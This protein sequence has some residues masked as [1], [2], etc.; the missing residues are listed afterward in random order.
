MLSS[1]FKYSL[2]TRILNSINRFRKCKVDN[3]N[4]VPEDFFQDIYLD[5]ILAAI[6]SEFPTEKNLAILDGGCGRGKITAAVAKCGHNVTG[7]D[8]HDLS[9]IQAG[10]ESKIMG[11]S[12]NLI[13]GDLL[14]VLKSIDSNTYHV[15]LCI[16]TLYACP[17]YRDII[18][19]FKRVIKIDGLFIATFRS[20]FYFITTLL[21][22]NQYEKA[23]KV[24]KSSEGIL[25]IASIPTYYNWQSLEEIDEIYVKN[26]L[27]ILKRTPVGAFCGTAYDGMSAI[28]NLENT[29]N[30]L[31]KSL[32]K[33]LEISEINDCEGIGR[34]TLVIGKNSNT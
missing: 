33:K 9:L 12:L 1:K 11:V 17:E 13:Q 18:T 24:A 31:E 6:S 21:L 14:K 10:H 34:F 32:L 2:L 4:F 8:Y 16:E 15:G 22:Q 23:L 7:I 19:E 3:P 20:K 26:G 28:C 27:K 5:H 25:R 29:P 30:Q